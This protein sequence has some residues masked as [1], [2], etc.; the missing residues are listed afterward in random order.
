MYQ[1]IDTPNLV[2]FMCDEKR[3]TA[4]PDEVAERKLP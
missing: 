4:L 1:K 2:I 3:L